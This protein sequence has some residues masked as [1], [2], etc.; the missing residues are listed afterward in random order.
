MCV[1]EYVRVEDVC[2]FVKVCVFDH[3]NGCLPGVVEVAHVDG[4]VRGLSLQ[5]GRM[6][7][8]ED[9]CVCECVCVRA[10]VHVNGCLLIGDEMGSLR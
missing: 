1:C 3:V 4:R 5:D 7:R 2:V 10:C 6:V 9:V 8:V